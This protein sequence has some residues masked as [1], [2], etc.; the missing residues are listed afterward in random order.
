MKKMFVPSIVYFQYLDPAARYVQRR[1]EG[2]EDPE[3][4]LA[5]EVSE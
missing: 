3:L 4:S 1:M 5:Y 2:E